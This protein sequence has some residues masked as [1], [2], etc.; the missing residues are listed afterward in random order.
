[1]AYIDFDPAKDLKEPVAFVSKKELM[2]RTGVAHTSMHNHI[3]SGKLDAFRFRN[4][5]Y[6]WPDE[7]ERYCIM[8][9]SGLLG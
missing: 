8:V 2:K 7:A 9:Q 5:T 1:M 3:V 4:R 6:I